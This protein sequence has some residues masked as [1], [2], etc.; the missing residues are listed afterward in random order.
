MDSERE[1]LLELLVSAVVQTMFE[2]AN[3]AFYVEMDVM[4]PVCS[5]HCKNFQNVVEDDEGDF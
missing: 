5:W 2:I 3:P 4:W 1:S